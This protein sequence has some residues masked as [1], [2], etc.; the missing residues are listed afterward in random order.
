MKFRRSEQGSFFSLDESIFTQETPYFSKSSFHVSG[1]HALANILSSFTKKP[2]LR[3]YIP[4]YYCHEV[5]DFVTA[6]VDVELYEC[7]P[8]SDRIDIT[9]R[10]DEAALI[11]EYFGAKSGV[12]VTGGKT[13]LDRTHDPFA[14]F[15]YTRSPDFVFGS[16]RKIAPLPDGGFVTPAIV[17]KMEEHHKTSDKHVSGV[18]EAMH[19]KEIYLSGETSEKL[20]YLESFAQFEEQLGDLPLSIE[21]SC[22]SR[23]RVKTLDHKRLRKAK[24]TNL[25]NLKNLLASEV[26]PFSILDFPAFAVLKFASQK[27]RDAFRTELIALDIYSAL[28][29]PKNQEFQSDIDFFSTHIF[30]HIDYRV[31]GAI[32]HLAKCLS[33][34]AHTISKQPN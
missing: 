1:R 2:I 21:M 8:T 25:E 16:L 12:S 27:N 15:T 30:I 32:P 28:L 23:K 14:D 5:T 6:L 18:L 7:S 26:L 19:R 29:W 3:L 4:S 11:V 13:L 33:I 9:I 10:D 34:S 17:T 31:D 24:T 20:D 22:Y